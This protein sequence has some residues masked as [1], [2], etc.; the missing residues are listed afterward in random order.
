V[1]TPYSIAMTPDSAAFWIYSAAYASLGGISALAV[2]LIARFIARP[3]DTHRRFRAFLGLLTI[4]A[5]VGVIASVLNYKLSTEAGISASR[6]VS[7]LIGSLLSDSVIFVWA[8][9][10]PLSRIFA[11]HG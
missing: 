1:P 4:V 5:L 6:R 8:S 10:F 3:F 9:G 7:G 11:R 2:G